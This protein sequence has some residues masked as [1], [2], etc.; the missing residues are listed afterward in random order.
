M[1]LLTAM[2][3]QQRE[4]LTVLKGTIDSPGF[5]AKGTTDMAIQ[6]LYILEDLI[7]TVVE[8]YL[9]HLSAL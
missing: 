4:P 5:S 2:G 6:L 7:K 9:G 3:F 1:E 8:Q